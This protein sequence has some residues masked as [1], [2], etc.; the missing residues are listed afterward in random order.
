MQQIYTRTPIPRC[1]PVNLLHIFRTPFFKNASAWLLLKNLIWLAG[2]R[3]N[4]TSSDEGF[5][6]QD[7]GSINS[8]YSNR[9]SQKK[10][11]Q[12]SVAEVAANFAISATCIHVERFIGRVRHWS[13]L[14]NK[15]P[16][17]RIDLLNLNTGKSLLYCIA[18]K[19]SDVAA[20]DHNSEVS[21]DDLNTIMDKKL[22]E[23]KSL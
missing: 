14:N 5:A 6:I 8:V 4:T 23:F 2:L 13:I 7:F 1:S 19:K 12:F 22:D 20:H 3:K 17:Q 10:N 16:A 18:V 21:N 9:S 11:S 15:C